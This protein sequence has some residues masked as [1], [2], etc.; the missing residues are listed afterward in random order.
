LNAA[1]V[2]ALLGTDR[3]CGM[4]ALPPKADKQQMA[5]FVRL[6]PKADSCSA[7]KYEVYSI[8]SSACASSMS[9]NVEA[10]YPWQF[11]MTAMV[12]HET[13]RKRAPQSFTGSVSWNQLR[14]KDA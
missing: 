3:R 6:V 10:G 4:S 13:G 1:E 12:K 8:P 11:S 7:A 5:W 2:D 14:R 9:G